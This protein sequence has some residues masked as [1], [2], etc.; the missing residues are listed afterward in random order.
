MRHCFVLG[1]VIRC[2][3]YG[4]SQESL[5]FWLTRRSMM[6]RVL[7]VV[8]NG[9]EWPKESAIPKEWAFVTATRLTA[10]AFR[11]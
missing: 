4:T 5:Q 6:H 9:K 10:D 2:I 11:Y 1:G 8:Q 7:Q 3:K